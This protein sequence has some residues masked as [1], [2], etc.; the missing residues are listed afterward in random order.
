MTK[1]KFF[2]V[3]ASLIAFSCASARVDGKK[4]EFPGKMQKRLR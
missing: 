1:S 3:A 2:L 4:D